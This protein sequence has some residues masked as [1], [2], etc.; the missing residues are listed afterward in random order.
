MENDSTFP[1]QLKLFQ[2]KLPE[3][4]INETISANHKVF[5]AL[6]TLMQKFP[7]IFLELKIPGNLTQ[8]TKSFF[9][10]LENPDKIIIIS[11]T[12]YQVEPDL[13]NVA[14][15]PTV[16][17]AL[18]RL[19]H[20]SG[21]ETTAQMLSNMPLMRSSC[22]NYL[23]HFKDQ[24]LG[25]S[26]VVKAL[27]ENPV[28]AA[29]TIEAVNKLD[30]VNTPFEDLNKAVSFVGVDG[31]RQILIEKAFSILCQIFSNQPDKLKHMRRCSTLAGLL[32][33]RFSDNPHVY[34]KMRSAALMHDIGSLLISF[35][36]PEEAA[37]C[38]NISRTKKIPTNEVENLLLGYNHLEAGMLL[39]KMMH[40]PEYLYPTISGHHKKAVDKDDI[41][42][43]ATMISN[44]YINLQ[45][46]HI[47][48]TEYDDCLNLLE[49]A[50]NKV[51]KEKKDKEFM[52]K[53]ARLQ[54]D[55]EEGL[56]KLRE[57]IYGK[58]EDL[59]PVDEVD[60]FRSK[61]LRMCFDPIDIEVVFKEK[62]ATI[63]KEGYENPIY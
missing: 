33:E 40:L 12:P 6:Q 7:V 13:T 8:D 10:N 37:R 15:L 29:E 14:V 31:V 44:G 34:W 25:F 24:N 26:D 35:Y 5:P 51:E 22:F 3:V 58:P 56:Q 55:D 19:K 45:S 11:E 21:I 36:D 53:A 23:E 43:L 30:R 47:G 16:Q 52:R 57:T 27:Q 4:I 28:I 54:K 38:R 18:L 2:N 1:F 42:L 50:K 62:L 32:G 48:Y 49:D 63:L 39:A 61:S 46:E 20:K 59:N 60:D 17:A 41:L 9:D